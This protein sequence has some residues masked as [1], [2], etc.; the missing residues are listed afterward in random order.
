MNKTVLLRGPFL[1][2]SGYGTHSRQIARWLFGLEES[3]NLS[4][5]VEALPWGITP[6]HVNKNAKDGLIGKL[7]SRTGDRKE[8]YDI[9]FQVQLPNE[10]N[11]QLGNF[12]VGITA[13]VETDKCN[14]AWI[15]CINRMNLVIV[16]SEFTKQTFLSTGTVNVPIL[17]IPESFPDEVLSANGSKLDLNLETDFNFLVFG[18]ITGNN[19]DN[20]RKNLFYTI[21]WMAELFANDP[22]VGI[23]LKT[24]MARATKIDRITTK[25]LLAKVLSETKCGPGPKFYLLHGSM[26]DDEIASLYVHPKIKA[27]VSLTR[28]EGFGLPLLEA[29]AS[30]LPVIA[31][32]W[33]AHK[34][35]LNYGKWTKVGFTLEDIHD[36]RIDNQIFMKGTKWSKPSEVEAKNA[37]K[38][39]RSS[40]ETPKEW[41]TDLKEKIRE[42][43]CFNSI[44]KQYSEQLEKYLD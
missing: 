7:L 27:L 42:K 16:P 9:T 8:K 34:E 4:I 39:F 31:T 23:V 14:P 25:N 18:Q 37:L 2:E 20:D 21:K 10:W 28:A 32:N 36:S 3:K 33:S 35:F 11:P 15:D 38:K 6:W 40:S 13:G 12:N 24:N 30:G 5:F 22:N 29:A 19:P 41:A 17:V 43:Y 26:E 1:T 44:S